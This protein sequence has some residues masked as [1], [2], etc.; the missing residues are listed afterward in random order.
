[1]IFHWIAETLRSSPELAIFLALAIG[2]WIGSRKFGSFSL[3][4]VTGTLLVGVLIGQLGI[5]I[6]PQVKSVFFIM[7]LF[8]VGFGVGPQFVRGIANNGLS[9]AL[10]AVVISSLCLACVYIAAI[11]SGYGPGMA[12]GLLAGS[13]TISASIGLATDAINRSGLSP[14]H[15]QEQ[16]NAIPVAYAVTYLFGTVGTGWILAFLGPKL[17][18]VNLEEECQRYERE[19]NINP[20]NGNS[21]TGWHQYI[22][23]AYRLKTLG[24]FAGKSVSSAEKL[25]Q[26]RIFVENIRRN[27][28]IIPFDGDTILSVGDCVAVSGPHDA[29]VYWSNNAEEVSDHDL[30]NIPIETVNVVIT[31]KNMNGQRLGLL[32]EAEYARGIYINNIHRGS[33]N[34]EIPLLSETD[35]FRGDI[36]S[37]TGSR[38]NIDK[39]IDEIGYADRPTDVTSMVL[40]G[41]GIFVGGLV[42]SIV[43]PIAGIPITLSASGGALIAGLVLGWL[44]GVTPKI[45]NVPNATVWFM[46]TVGLNIFIAVV[47]ISAGPT[48]IKGLQVAGVSVFLWGLFASAVPMILAPLIGKYIFRFDPAINLGCCGGARTSTA[49]VAMVAD[50]AK[51]NVPMLGYTVPYAVSNT[52][53]TM[54]GLVIV[55]LLS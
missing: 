55:I 3:G 54:W 19:M 47:G 10:F 18:R 49:S 44:R 32:A 40:V 38:R 31:N 24:K 29:L 39:L 20:V 27:G 9:Q 23:R 26:D 21:E 42:G 7:F 36:I 1:M 16:L 52:L 37:I 22:M 35:I 28:K 5:V 12:E 4:A 45:G 50:V 2:F 13:Q 15:I 30:I 14:D 8:G 25:A 43:L 6:S 41:G 46:N 33:M 53:L 17:L 51:S 11:F 34:V 48:F